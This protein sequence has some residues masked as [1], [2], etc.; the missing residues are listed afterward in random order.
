MPSLIH[1]PR[2]IVLVLVLVAATACNS[3][4][5]TPVS[6][7]DVSDPETAGQLAAGF[8][9]LENDRRWTADEFSVLLQPPPGADEH[10][11]YLRLKFFI[12]D[13]EIQKTGPLAL[14]AEVENETLPA[15]TISR[16]GFYTYARQVPVEA[17]QSSLVKVV[18]DFDKPYLPG[19]GD[20][21]RLG[22]VVS[23]VALS[24]R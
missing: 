6:A 21:R 18:F 15:Q 16:G 13:D 22:A 7:I 8:Y 4:R 23:S 9:G 12:P 10:G 14:E 24:L 17:L 20:A 11:A 19:N 5:P 2:T 1:R 3:R